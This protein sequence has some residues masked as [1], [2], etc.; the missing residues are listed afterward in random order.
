MNHFVLL[1]IISLAIAVVFTLIT[2]EDKK[3]QFKYFLKIILYMVVGSF[4]AGW[5]MSAIPW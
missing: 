3:E 2:K 4:V 1:V 5:V